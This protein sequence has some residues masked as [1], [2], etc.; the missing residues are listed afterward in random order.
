[1]EN[2]TVAREMQSYLTSFARTG[3]PNSGSARLDMVE[4]GESQ[5]VLDISE[6]GFELS[7]DDAANERCA[8]WLAHI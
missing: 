1:M 5:T 4:Y 2:A 8:W 3:N 6:R 7:R